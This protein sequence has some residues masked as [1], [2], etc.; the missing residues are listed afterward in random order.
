MARST[1]LPPNIKLRRA[2]PS[3]AAAIARMSHDFRAA[4]GEPPDLLDEAA[5]RRD[6]FGVSPEFE[7]ILAEGENGAV[8]YALYFDSYEPTYAAR[9]LYLAD[10][11]VDQAFRRQG[12]A[13][14]LLAAVAA[15]S[16][17]R[18][19]VFVWW[20][21]LATN[22]AAHDFYASLGVNAVPMVAYAATEFSIFEQL[23]DAAPPVER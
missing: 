2:G 21:R 6:G 5:V 20:V 10:L 17:D 12:I 18:G 22:T 11:Y 7:V 3:D 1:V 23:A 16:R 9:G 19:R 13:R 14:A 4:L 8:G 15:E